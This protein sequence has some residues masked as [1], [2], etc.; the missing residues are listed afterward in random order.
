VV[1]LKALI[2][3]AA[4]HAAAEI[5]CGPLRLDTVRGQV[6]HDHLPLDLTALEFKVLSYLILHRAKIVSATEL[7]DHVYGAEADPDSNLINVIIGRIRKK[8]GGDL[9]TTIRGR[10]YRMEQQ[11]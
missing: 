2:R 6:F 8:I 11:Q 7:I 1:R 3:R 5:E 4:G 9:I 10:G